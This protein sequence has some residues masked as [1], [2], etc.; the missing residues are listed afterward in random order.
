ML[1][2]PDPGP[3]TEDEEVDGPK[4]DAEWEEDEGG[5]EETTSERRLALNT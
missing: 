1:V 2:P 4:E 5:D 3:V